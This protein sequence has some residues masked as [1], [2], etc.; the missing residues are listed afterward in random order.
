[1]KKSTT[2]ISVFGKEIAFGSVPNEKFEKGP[3]KHVTVMGIIELPITYTEYYVTEVVEQRLENDQTQAQAKAE[4]SAYSEL[5]SILENSELNK[6]TKTIQT[7]ENGV[8]VIID[9]VCEKEI[10]VPKFRE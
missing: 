5:K 1:V 8:T 2:V 4:Y 3:K 6:I 10:G 7:D 9:Y